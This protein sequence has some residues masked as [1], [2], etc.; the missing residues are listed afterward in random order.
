M[1]SHRAV[2]IIITVLL[3]IIIVGSVVILIHHTC[4]AKNDKGPISYNELLPLI[5]LLV[6]IIAIITAA[7]S[8]VGFFYLDKFLEKRVTEITDEKSRQR[9]ED[10]FIRSVIDT[11]YVYYTLINLD[12]NMV[13]LAIDETKRVFQYIPNEY[14]ECF[15]KNNLAFYH[16]LR[17]GKDD[18][19][20]A[21]KYS[22]FIFEKS[23]KFFISKPDDAIDWRMTRAY[24]MAKHPIDSKEKADAKKMYEGLLK[25]E[26]VSLIQADKIKAHI[27]RFWP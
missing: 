19:D 17:G 2:P 15:A 26:K 14:L 12:P 9:S 1:G 6:T 27:K 3:V 4:Y 11:G 10:V 8:V 21:R 22:E 18:I 13:D 5:A 25:I 20:I 16:A 23:S 7:F 24:V